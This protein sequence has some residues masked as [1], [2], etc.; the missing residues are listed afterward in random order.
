MR[1]TFGE[2]LTLLHYWSLLK[3]LNTAHTLQWSCTFQ[4]IVVTCEDTSVEY[5]IVKNDSLSTYA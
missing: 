4:F 2:I 3:T 1:V 5:N